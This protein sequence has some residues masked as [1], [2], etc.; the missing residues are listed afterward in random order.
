MKKIIFSGLILMLFATAC[1]KKQFSDAY[2]NPT[3]LAETTVDRQFA[4]VLAS[5][6]NY[7][8]YHYWDYFVVYQ[9]TVIPWSQ[10]AV[11]LNSNGRYIPGAAAVSDFWNN[12]YNLV[13]QYKDLL[14]VYGIL[15]T[16]DQ[17]NNKI[18]VIAATI[19]RWQGSGARS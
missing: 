2:T 1:T 4:G 10:T 18:Y 6:L 7:V 17:T 9:N 8:M 12:Y 16:A 15:S 5:E 11:T 14:K 3:K 19:L 13:A